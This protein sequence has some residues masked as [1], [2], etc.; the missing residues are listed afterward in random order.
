MGD[1]R[2]RV[3]CDR[4]HGPRRDRDGG[5]RMDLSPAAQQAADPAAEDTHNCLA[6]PRPLSGAATH[7]REPAARAGATRQERSY[8]QINSYKQHWRLGGEVCTFA[9]TSAGRRG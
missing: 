8:N 1:A 7:T 6:P 2:G 4:R 3:G 5:Y 9:Q